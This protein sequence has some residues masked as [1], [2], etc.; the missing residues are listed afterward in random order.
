VLKPFT[1]IPSVLGPI[2]VSFPG[3]VTVSAKCAPVG[4]MVRLLL[5]EMRRK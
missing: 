1:A 5:D 4:L 3:V 2:G